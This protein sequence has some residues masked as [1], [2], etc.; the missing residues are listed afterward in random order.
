VSRGQKSTLSNFWSLYHKFYTLCS[1]PPL[2]HS[3]P[4]VPF[5]PT[6]TLTNYQSLS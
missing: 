6:V 4:H 3:Y 2:S 5:V 1:Q